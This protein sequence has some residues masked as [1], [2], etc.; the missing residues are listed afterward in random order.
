MSAQL[1][2]LKNIW[3]TRRGPIISGIVTVLVLAAVIIGVAALG[4]TQ[5]KPQ[6]KLGLGTEEVGAQQY[7]DQANLALA[8]GDTTAALTL[9]NK[10]LKTDPNNQT[11]LVVVREV[12][13]KRSSS[14][15]SNGS[16][17]G[18]SK[19]TSPGSPSADPDQ[20][21]TTKVSDL[22]GLLP[23]TFQNY[24]LGSVTTTKNET[25]VSGTPISANQE[26]TQ[27]IWT[28]HQTGSKAEATSY[29]T[30]VSKASFP[31]DAAWVGVDGA[32]SYFGTD[33]TRFA[34]IAYVRG[35]YAFEALLTSN[36]GKPKD[37]RVL[38]Q[39]AAGGFADAP[40]E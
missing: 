17:G 12:R 37:L 35:I 39:K 5:P 7:A 20:G 26:A 30:K 40:P 2:G 23:G 31:N 33:G 29:I 24:F 11:A 8:S 10:A 18:S 16:S 21:F 14:S 4:P 15:N 13:A 19:S 22:A 28:V 32:T 34:T 25:Q 9:A 27:I 6:T 1:G 36:Q 3:A 38:A